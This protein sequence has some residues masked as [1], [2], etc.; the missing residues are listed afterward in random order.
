[1]TTITEASFNVFHDLIT[2]A[3]ETNNIEAARARLAEA[4]E[5]LPLYDVSRLVHEIEAEYGS[6]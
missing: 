4:R 5:C 2:I 6:I 3:M 1:M